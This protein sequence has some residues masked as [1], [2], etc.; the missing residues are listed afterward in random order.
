MIALR[1]CSLNVRYYWKESCEA[2]RQKTLLSSRKIPNLLDQPR[3]KSAK[4]KA[5]GKQIEDVKMIKP[6][7][8]QLEIP[9]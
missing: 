6:G 9:S 2:S 5:L 1:G 7:C 8:V 3:P 4:E